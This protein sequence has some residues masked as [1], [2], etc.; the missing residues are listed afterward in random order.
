MA[1]P[2][3]VWENTWT[4]LSDDILHRQR[5]ILDNPDLTLSDEEL[6]D[7]IL[8]D[9]EHK[10]KSHNKSLKDFQSM[11]YPDLDAYSTDLVTIGV[12]RLI[13]DELCY[14]R[15]RLS[16]EYNIQ[17]SQLTNEQKGKTFVWKTLAS[18]LRS[19]GQIVLTVASSGIAS[20]LLPGGRTAHARFAIPLNLDEFSTRNIK[21]G[22]PLADLLIKTKLIIWDEAPMV[23]RYCIEGLDRTMR[24][25]L[26]FNNSRSEEQPFGGKTI[27]FGG[28]FRQILPV[29]PKRT[30]QEIVNATINSSYIWN[31]CK[32]MTLMKNMRLEGANGNQSC[33]ELKEFAY[34]ILSIGDGRCERFMDGADNVEI[35]D[36]ILIKEWDDPIVAICREIYPEMTSEM[37]CDMQVEDRAILTPT[38]ELV[39][40][41]NRYM[42][43]L[44]PTEAQT[45]FSSDKAC[46]TENNNDILASVHTPELLNTIRCSGVPNHDLTLKVG[47]PIMLLRNIDH[48]AGLCNGTRMVLTKLGKHI[49]EAK[50]ISGKNASQKVFIPRMTL[51]PSDYRIPFK[52]QRRQ[53]PIMVSYA[54]T[55]NKSQGQSLSKVGLILKKLVFTHG[56]L[57]VAV[58]RVT[59]KKGLKILLCHDDDRVKETD[60]VVYK[61]VFRN[62]E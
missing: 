19:K 60:N 59:N 17:L 5:R 40:E 58:S 57:Y 34:W 50:S 24:D 13:C 55:I 20:L 48:S 37:N 53:F 39:D 18:G 56:Q 30:R 32:L 43:S 15:R 2:E 49:L 7:F 8:I 12:N 14:D 38:L 10:L 3:H 27:V 36:D 35:L 9:I 23:N 4:L 28:D 25:I 22:S 16:N 46:P 62:L 51:S 54:M 52:F 33:I 21:Q 6:K 31:I 44:N 42:M 45:Y 61:E 29:I 47:T 41:I 11:P 1:R 26:R